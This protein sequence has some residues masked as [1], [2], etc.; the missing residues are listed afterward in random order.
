MIGVILLWSTIYGCS[1]AKE[2]NDS[3]TVEAAFSPQA[4]AL[5]LILRSI[6]E[7]KTSI[8]IAAYSFTSK[9][10]ATA[11]RDAHHRGVKVKLVADVKANRKYSAIQFLANAGVPVR[12][13]DKFA[14]LHDKYMVIDE[15]IVQTGSFNYTAAAATRNAENVIVIRDSAIAHQYL[16]D[17]Q[18]LWK[19]GV[20]TQARY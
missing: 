14:I 8:H 4:G 18:G 1:V 9:P 2:R 12:T 20:D 6:H 15:S 11:L 5:E 16:S 17:W 19:S 3:P 13:N 7:A 10:I